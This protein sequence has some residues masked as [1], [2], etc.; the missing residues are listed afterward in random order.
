MKFLSLLVRVL[1]MK[2]AK[3][4]LAGCGQHDKATPKKLRQWRLVIMKAVDTVGVMP[5]TGLVSGH[6]HPREGLFLRWSNMRGKAR[7]PF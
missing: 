6:K 1:P 5:G 4:V 2:R 3:V 7:C